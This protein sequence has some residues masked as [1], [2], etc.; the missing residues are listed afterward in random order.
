VDGVA[1]KFGLVLLRDETVPP[2]VG[3]PAKHQS[4][5]HYIIALR[6]GRAF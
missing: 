4:V 1:E 5:L 6:S 3:F 2:V